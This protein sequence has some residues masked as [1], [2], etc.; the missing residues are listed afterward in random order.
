MAPPLL[1]LLLLGH[2]RSQALWADEAEE[3]QLAGTRWAEVESADG[4][5]ASLQTWKAV[6]PRKGMRYTELLESRAA[7]S[8][9][10]EVDLSAVEED[11]MQ[12]KTRQLEVVAFPVGIAIGA[13][14][15]ALWPS[16]F[17]GRTT[18]TTTTVA[19]VSADGNL[20]VGS[21]SDAIVV[22]GGSVS[23]TSTTTETPT[24]P[25]PRTV[26][27]DFPDCGEKGS[28]TR[29]IGGA[30]VVENE[31]PWLCSLTYNR[32]RLPVH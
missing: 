23:T 30:E 20:A 16:L 17:P 22:L 8:E 19:S 9:K 4:G 13:V 7:A 15:A 28:A 31:Y 32:Y 29:V 14:G 6:A 18:T 26:L 11:E 25:S 21:D 12:N 2:V 24:T 10:V 1:L 27:A 3:T 5:P